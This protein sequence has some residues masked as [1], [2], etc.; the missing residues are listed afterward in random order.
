[1][2]IR[3]AR[4]GRCQ[5]KSAD[6]TGCLIEHFG[7]A[8]AVPQLPERCLS[9]K[10]GIVRC[11]LEKEIGREESDVIYLSEFYFPSQNSEANYLAKSPRA[12][13]T[14][15]DS[16]YPFGLFAGRGLKALDL[17]D[18]TILY[19][20]NGSGKTTALNVMADALRLQRGAQY[21]RSDFFPDYVSLC[22]FHTLHAIPAG[23]LILTSDD[24]FDYMLDV[25]AI[26]DNIDTRRGSLFDEYTEAR[27]A[28]FQMH[29]IEDYDRLKQVSAARRYSKSQVA[30]KTLSPNIR[31]HSNGESAFLMFQEKL[32]GD[33]LYLL[34]EP[35]NSLSAARQIA[36][37]DFL[38]DSARFYGCQFVLATH[39][40]FLLA[41][42]G[43]RI[44]DLDS[45][46]VRIRR[47]TELESVRDTFEFFQQHKEEF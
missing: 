41:I 12:K 43:A 37:A 28:K 26:N 35:E 32:R 30:R 3:R 39:S 2:P 18:V 21:N 1:M 11:C 17:A 19:G 40:P 7:N 5:A 24:V 16:F 23:S 6:N 10:A 36:L 45:D 42:P 44:Y 33:A 25:R 20:G 14:C 31:T 47:W 29:S 15:Y 46:P 4:C 22:Q 9:R 13:M 38:A 34:D 8:D 27:T